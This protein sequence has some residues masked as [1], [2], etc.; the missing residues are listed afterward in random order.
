MT[1]DTMWL[2]DPAVWEAGVPHDRFA[3]LRRDEPV[4]WHEHPEGLRGFWVLARHADVIAASRDPATFSSRWGVVNLDDLSA[5]QLDSRRTFLEED[6]P[7]H[8]AVRG[9]LEA[10]FTPRAVAAFEAVVRRL[11]VEVIAPVVAAG[12]GDVVS[13]VAEDV[14]IRLL[15]RLLGVDEAHVDDLVRWGNELLAAPPTD[16]D[17]EF[18][19][20]PF[21]SPL[22]LRVFELADRLADER[23][24]TPTD[25]ATSALVNGRVD[26]AP[27]SPEEYRATWLML[28]IAGNETTRHAISHGVL[29]L[30]EHPDQLDRWRADPG[31][32]ASAVEEILRVATPISW[33]RRQVTTDV[34]L[35]GRVLRAGDKVLL[36]FT[37]ANRDE[38]VFADPMRFDV[39]RR[40]NP[41]VTFGR[42]GPHFCLGAHVARLELKVLF[43]ELVG[44]IRRVE[45][46]G[47]VRRLRSN[48][49]N[50]IVELPV[51][52]T[53]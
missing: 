22:S 27:L 16:P 28:V 26:G 9:L 4:S 35:G 10:R 7:R 43:G 21:G 47:P 49:L 50:G 29:A 12:G 6:P 52:L 31:L 39:G 53:A 32:G 2:A 13:A 51:S 44:R 18:A 40:P 15:A 24:V 25:D 42:G 3:R 41:H 20:L 8:T 45:L 5:E 17:G 36:S 23:R 1:A 14:P 30:A 48:H 19:H 38:A 34:E 37:S 11:A 46:A 33:H